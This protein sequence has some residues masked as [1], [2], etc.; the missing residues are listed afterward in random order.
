MFIRR[1]RSDD[2]AAVGAVL[3]MAFATA[4]EAE[5]TVPVE[6]GLVKELRADEGWLPALSLVAVQPG[7]SEVIGH[8]VCTRGS[9]DGSPAL[10]LGPLA[11]RPDRQRQGVGTALMHA[12]L[13]AADALEE[14]LVALLGDP[15][16]YSRFGFLPAREYDI[17]PPNPEWGR[18][19][20]V[21]ALS[22]YRSLSGT[23]SYAKPFGRL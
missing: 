21:R 22:A 1:E 6:V 13:G 8:V 11:V 19:F 2:D 14:P 9:V 18:H 12:V 20:Q 15:S 10:G 17:V 7:D 16:Y 23:F 4:Q 5:R 3:A